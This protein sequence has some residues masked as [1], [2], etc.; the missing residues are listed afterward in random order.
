[1]LI[2]A[3]NTAIKLARQDKDD[4]DTACRRARCRTN[5]ADCFVRT[6]VRTCGQQS[7][8]SRFYGEQDKTRGV[9]ERAVR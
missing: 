4:D 9:R 3:N 8:L 5:G 1:M 6:A 2:G 7:W